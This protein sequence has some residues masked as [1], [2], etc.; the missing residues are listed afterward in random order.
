MWSASKQGG[1]LTTAG[2]R[3]ADIG[4]TGLKDLF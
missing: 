3:L 1:Y 2:K 4:Y